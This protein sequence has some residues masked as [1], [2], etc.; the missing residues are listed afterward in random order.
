MDTLCIP[1]RQDAW[2][3]K[4]SQI[5]KMAS[6]Y[7]GAISSLV[8]DA[9]LMATA[10]KVSCVAAE[11]NNTSYERTT[12]APY[13]LSPETRARISCSTWMCR[14]WTLQEGQLPA[15]IAIQFLDGAVVLEGR[16]SKS[17]HSFFPFQERFTNYESLV[18][19][20]PEDA[21]EAIVS[22]SQSTETKLTRDGGL[23]SWQTMHLECDCA[24]IALTR[25]F[26]SIFFNTPSFVSVWNELTGRSTTMAEDLPLIIT[27]ILNLDNRRLLGLH[28]SGEMFETIILS[29]KRT[30]LSLLFNTGLRKDQ[31]SAQRNRWVPAR[32]DRDTL[33]NHPMLDIKRSHLEWDYYKKPTGKCSAYSIDALLPL[34]STAYLRDVQ[35]DISYAIKPSIACADD[36]VTAG[37]TSTCVIFEDAEMPD[38]PGVKRGACFLIESRTIEHVDMTFICPLRLHSRQDVASVPPEESN[39]YDLAPINCPARLRISYGN[40]YSNLI[41][42]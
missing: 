18:V 1:V 4:L 8:L 5:D 35:N 15:A 2:S 29:L 22:V 16:D 6:I 34:G 25:S 13:R 20:D 41:Q 40:F 12:A 11:P 30:P 37:F 33:T 31:E 36:N 3:L 7:K 27:N 42:E 19:T 17:N 32:V 38:C 28:D 9:E 24:D 23:E 10:R 26:H 14:C 21:S 39:T